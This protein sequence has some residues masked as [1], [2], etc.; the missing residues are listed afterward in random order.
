VPIS[1]AVEASCAVPGVYPPVEIDGRA[2]VDG[3]LLKTVHASVALEHGVELLFCVNPIVPVDIRPGVRAGTMPRDILVERGLPTLLSQT[4]RTLVHS[5]LRVGF[6]RYAA[7]FP[8]AD[9]V[10][11]E[12]GTDE[13]RMFFSNMF[14]FRARREV[15]ELAYRATRRD[16]WERRDEL[17]PVLAR[18]GIVF[19]AD[20][21]AD[22]DR[23]LWEHVGLPAGGPA[24]SARQLGRSLDR[25][26]AAVTVL[27]REIDAK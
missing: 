19:R 16:L 27:E 11:F 1:R 17:E 9:V 22:E 23:D 13:Y 12:P 14:S 4:F 25:L 15:C 7:R 3:V 10:L 20:V 8:R 2:C 5:R 21:L 26:D 6:A 18:H 24:A